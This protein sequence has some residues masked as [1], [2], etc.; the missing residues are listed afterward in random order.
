MFAWVEKKKIDKINKSESIKIYRKSG[1][2]WTRE[3]NK[4]ED[5]ESSTKMIIA[6]NAKKTAYITTLGICLLG[7]HTFNTFWNL[8][9]WKSTFSYYKPFKLGKSKLTLLNQY[10]NDIIKFKIKVCSNQN[11]SDLIEI[12]HH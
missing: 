10:F 5:N 11:F 12:F 8:S 4:E 7:K 1:L 6:V 3:E 9:Q 2:E